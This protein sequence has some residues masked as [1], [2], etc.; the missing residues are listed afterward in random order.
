MF[1]V[2]HREYIIIRMSVHI[3][4]GCVFVRVDGVY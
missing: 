4:V 2:K 1:Y 3:L